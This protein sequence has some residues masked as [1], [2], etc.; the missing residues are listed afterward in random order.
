LQFDFAGTAVT[1]NERRRVGRAAMVTGLPRCGEGFDNGVNDACALEA[2]H[3]QQRQ[4]DDGDSYIRSA[5][6]A[7]PSPTVHPWLTV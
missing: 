3:M 7:A 4:S 5:V 6:P 2:L 1:Q